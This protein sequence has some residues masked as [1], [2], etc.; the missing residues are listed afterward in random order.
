MPTV[1]TVLLRI[2][3][4]GFEGFSQYMVADVLE[5]ARLFL[6]CSLGR[7]KWYVFEKKYLKEEMIYNCAFFT[8]PKNVFSF[9]SRLLQ[10]DGAQHDKALGPVAPRDRDGVRVG[11][12]RPLHHR[13]RLRRHL[14][15]RPG[16]ADASAT[17]QAG[18]VQDDWRCL[19]CGHL[20]LLVDLL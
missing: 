6:I 15:H 10:E 12:R 18:A 11:G 16:T 8:A 13:L 4:N 14:V 20:K 7:N 3:Q 19:P 5:A 1:L 9:W 17:V 2:Y